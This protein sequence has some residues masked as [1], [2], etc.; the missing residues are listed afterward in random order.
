MDFNKWFL[1]EK[2]ADAWIEVGAAQL[3]VHRLI[4]S[5]KSEVFDNFF[6]NN[7]KIQLSGDRYPLDAVRSLLEYIYTDRFVM[8]DIAIT[9]LVIELAKMFKVQS[10][11]FTVRKLII[12]ML[13]STGDITALNFFDVHQLVTQSKMDKFIIERVVK[14]GID[15]KFE[16][17]REEFTQFKDCERI[18]FVIEV[19]KVNQS[20]IIEALSSAV[21]A[22]SG[23]SQQDFEQ[24]I[25]LPKCSLRDLIKLKESDLFRTENLTARINGMINQIVHFIGSA[26][27]GT[28]NVMSVSNR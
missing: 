16:I 2:F 28:I 3:P 1:Q 9:P 7:Q 8:R 5:N 19:L 17:L 11:H 20:V 14:F 15:N 25:E 4:L 26:Q 12:Q 22:S 21:I 10:L 24:F 6:T 27:L 18:R 13:D 23:R